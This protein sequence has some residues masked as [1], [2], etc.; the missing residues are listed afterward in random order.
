MIDLRSDTV[1]QPTPAMRQAMAAAEVGDDVYSEDPTV[2]R[3]EQEAATIF[4]REAAIFVPTGTM[5]NQI[6][7]RLHTEHGQEVICEARSHILDWEMAM[8]AA[9]SGCQARTVAGERGILTWSQIKPAIG[10]K[11]YYRAQTG[12]ICIENTHNMAGGTVTPLP[13]LE[14]IWTGARDAGL[15]VHLDGA[16]VFNAATALGI[17]VAELTRGF[18]TVMFCLSK[19]LGAPVGSMLVGSREAIDRARIFRKALGGGMRQAGVLAAAGLIALKEMLAR[20]GDDHA[21]AR[22]IAEAIAADSTA[23][24]DL[25]AVQTNIVIFTLRNNGDASAF[26]DALKQKG[27]LAS[28][29]GPHSV[30]FVTHYDVDRSACEEAAS[31]IVALL[32][33]F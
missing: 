29:V 8:T 5:G 28:S 31:I 3:L 7:I 6:A 21:N 16:R 26:C 24:I 10:A 15:P 32:R 19:G 23:E 9:F 27:V 12:L 14:E 18:D 22:L 30:R 13:I 2:N 17:G 33:S 1:T 4:G 25:D 20:L 11:I